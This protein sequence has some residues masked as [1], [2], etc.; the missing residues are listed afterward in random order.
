L[1]S[2]E[3]PGFVAITGNIPAGLAALAAAIPFARS[4]DAIVVLELDPCRVSGAEE[5]GTIGTNEVTARGSRG[6][7]SPAGAD[8]L[9]ISAL[10]GTEAEGEPDEAVA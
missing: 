1:I 3:S 7:A 8:V 2:D 6:I 5:V 9:L 10:L 4:A